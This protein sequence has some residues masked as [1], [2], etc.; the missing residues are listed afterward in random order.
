VAY[1]DADI[2]GRQYAM[3]LMRAA[4]TEPRIDAG[5]SILGRREGSERSLKPILFGSHIDSVPS[6]GNFDGDLGSMSAIWS[7]TS[8]RVALSIKPASRSGWLKA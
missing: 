1:S 2:A 4:G 8:S 6:G 3:E 5:G 7:C